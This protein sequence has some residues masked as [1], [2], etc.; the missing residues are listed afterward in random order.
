MKNVEQVTKNEER[1]ERM[2]TLK[3]GRNI[4][5]EKLKSGRLKSDS[6]YNLI[7]Y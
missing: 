3:F 7:N 5:D 4:E 2:K 1:E 6:I